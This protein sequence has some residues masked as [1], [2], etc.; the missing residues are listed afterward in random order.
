VALRRRQQQGSGK[1]DER[2]A[3]RQR[4]GSGDRA[5]AAMTGKRMMGVAWRREQRGGNNGNGGRVA[6]RQGGE[7]EGGASRQRCEKRGGGGKVA[8]KGAW[9][10]L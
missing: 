3:R 8:G 10:N 7:A 5:A 6:W 1:G 9:L 2:V 4:Q